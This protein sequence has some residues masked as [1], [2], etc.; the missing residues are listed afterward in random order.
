MPHLMLDIL[1]EHLEE[2][3]F[4]SIQ[5][6]KMLFAP[7]VTLRGFLEHEQRVSAHWDGLKVGRDASVEL[8]VASLEEFDPW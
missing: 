3:A 7:A 8:A 5:R 1:Q 6:R 4:L 2:L